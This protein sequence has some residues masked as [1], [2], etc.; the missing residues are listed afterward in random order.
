MDDL[1]KFAAVA[2]IVAACAVTVAA[3]YLAR[4]KYKIMEDLKKV[5]YPYP[6]LPD[7]YPFTRREALIHD[8]KL[9]TIRQMESDQWAEINRI[10]DI[11]NARAEAAAKSTNR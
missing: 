2:Q 4:F 10:R 7:D 3:V 9:D 6:Q 11:C 5:F 8:E 1:L